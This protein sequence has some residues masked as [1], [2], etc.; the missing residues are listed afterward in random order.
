M[1]LSPNSGVGWG[2]ANATDYLLPPLLP[3]LMGRPSRPATVSILVAQIHHI[4][5]GADVCINSWS[6]PV[7]TLL[8]FKCSSPTRAEIY[9]LWMSPRSGEN[10][11]GEPS[12][13]VGISQHPSLLKS[14]VCVRRPQ[15]CL[16]R[17][18]FLKINSCRRAVNCMLGVNY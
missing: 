4:S 18:L 12:T 10:Q 14:L 8:C 3:R 2:A 5:R 7:T 9:T 6:G 15:P 11:Q 1:F 17:Q 16:K 13:L